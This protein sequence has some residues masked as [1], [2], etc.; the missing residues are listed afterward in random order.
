MDEIIL[1]T[2][3]CPQC[4]VLKKKLDLRNIQYTE[5]TDEEQMRELNIRDL[6]VLSVNGELKSMAQAAKWI[7]TQEVIK[8]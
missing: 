7:N 8:C 1:Y 5:N 4:N 3:G 2:I 6:P